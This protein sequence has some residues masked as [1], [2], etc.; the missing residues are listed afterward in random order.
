MSVLAR[1]ALLRAMDQKHISI[2]P[3][4]FSQ[5]GPASYDLTLSNDFRRFKKIETPIDVN[6]TVDYK[7]YTELVH[8]PDDQVFLLKPFESCLAITR[9]TIAL[10]NQYCG[11]LVRSSTVCL[12]TD[13]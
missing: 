8:V 2:E 5:L 4:N 13:S 11:L 1:D 7:E 10:G 6:E 9:E 3:F 12:H